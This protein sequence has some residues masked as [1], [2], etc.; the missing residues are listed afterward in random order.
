MRRL[1][2]RPV[3][4]APYPLAASC[5][6]FR[7]YLR[8][9]D[10]T[11]WVVRA[12][13]TTNATDSKRR[14]GRP[15]PSEMLLRTL[16][17]AGDRLVEVEAGRY[18]RTLAGP[19]GADARFEVPLGV[20]LNWLTGETRD[21]SVGGGAE[22]AQLYLAQWR[23]RDEVPGLAEVIRPPSM[24]EPLLRSGVVDLY[25]SSF[26]IGPSAAVSPLHRDPYDNLYHL[27]ASSMPPAHAKHFLLLPPALAEAL[28]PRNGCVSR[29][30]SPFD[31]HVRK[32]SDTDVVSGFEVLVDP[33]SAPARTAQAVLSSG[34]ALS[35]VLHEG[36]MLFLPRGWWHRVENVQVQAAGVPRTPGVG[37]E[38]KGRR[39]WT[40]GVGWWFLP[41]KS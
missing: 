15:N 34:S 35:C 30:T 19:P 40:A 32:T 29:N 11:P 33:S 12:D 1:E 41:R 2:T 5:D 22:G 13:E 24:L 3:P 17:V 4:D 6:A 16:R 8:S 27:A 10:R 23:A 14:H 26:F 25:Q 20:Y 21:T 36:D 31:V 7:E 39:G 18:D 38:H 37:G 9:P 28:A